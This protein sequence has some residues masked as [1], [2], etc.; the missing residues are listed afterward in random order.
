MG[1]LCLPCL[2][3]HEGGVW[4]TRWRR[5]IC[6][7]AAWNRV[8]DPGEAAGTQV[9]THLTSLQFEAMTSAPGFLVAD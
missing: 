4:V 8:K 3:E 1:A 6:V 2:G 7:G 5:V 9:P